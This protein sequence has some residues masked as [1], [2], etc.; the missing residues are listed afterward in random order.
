MADYLAADY[1]ESRR[2]G[3]MEAPSPDA[4]SIRGRVCRLTNHGWVPVAPYRIPPYVPAVNFHTVRNEANA[5]L[6]EM[7]NF[8][9]G[10][11]D[12]SVD[13]L[14]FGGHGDPS[15]GGGCSINGA[16]VMADVV[17]NDNFGAAVR[18]V[19]SPNALVVF[20]SCGSAMD[21]RALRSAA[22][23]LGTPVAGIRGDSSSYCDNNWEASE[24]G[25]WEIVPPQNGIGELLPS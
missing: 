7:I 24:G 25:W 14:V 22:N 1:P 3:F 6:T 9:S 23:A 13:V 8:L 5:A 12:H 19:L 11:S 20:A 10:F 2:A 16:N 21:R 15:G 17:G 4:N 18:Q